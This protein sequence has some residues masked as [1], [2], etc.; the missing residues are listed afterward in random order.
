[1]QHLQDL[2]REQGVLAAI[3]ELWPG[4]ARR[5]RRC[6]CAEPVPSSPLAGEADL[7]QAH[8]ERHPRGRGPGSP[9]LG[10]V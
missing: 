6:G 10:G 1:M 2:L 4:G 5:I 7:G 8:R 9:V 3:A